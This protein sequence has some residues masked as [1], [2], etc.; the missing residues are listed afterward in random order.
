MNAWARQSHARLWRNQNAK[1]P[2]ID[3]AES[4]AK[5]E[6]NLIVQFIFALSI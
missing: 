6:A 3:P 2:R 5:I 4:A 1:L